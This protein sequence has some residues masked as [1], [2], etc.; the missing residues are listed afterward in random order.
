[1]MKKYIIAVS[2]AM[3]AVAGPAIAFAADV[4]PPV[5]TL[6][7]GSV[8]VAQ[9]DYSDPG[10]SATD[11][12][13]GNITSSV[14]VSGLGTTPGNYTLNYNVSDS[15]GNAAVTQHRSV[16]IYANGMANPCIVNNTCPC[17][18]NTDPLYGD[19]SAWKSCVMQKYP[20]F[21]DGS[22]HVCR[23]TPVAMGEA[24]KCAADQNG[25]TNL[26]IDETGTETVL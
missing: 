5:I 17:P 13:D 4:T 3:A 20:K 14:I 6:F 2:I 12:T 16:S 21:G 11:D 7:G 22:T 1:M 18:M 25:Y 23:L 15:S 8:T 26:R 10:Y 24:P 9:G 19:R